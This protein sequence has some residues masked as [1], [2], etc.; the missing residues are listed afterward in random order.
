MEQQHHLQMSQEVASKQIG[1]TMREVSRERSAALASQRQMDSLSQTLK[2]TLDQA[3]MMVREQENERQVAQQRL[4][5]S[6]TNVEN[7]VGDVWNQLEESV[8][9]LL[10]QQSHAVH[11]QTETVQTLERLNQT[12]QFL[13]SVSEHT[14]EQLDW[15]QGLVGKT[16]ADFN[17]LK[18]EIN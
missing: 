11:L 5:E 7:H 14:K 18:P 15:I 4:L 16:G 13:L 10:D 6:L 2:A 1:Q 12:F 8:A 9:K 3:T 17:P